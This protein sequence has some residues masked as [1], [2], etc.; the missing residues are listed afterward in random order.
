MTV[1]SLPFAIKT[2]P[3]MKAVPGFKYE[4]GLDVGI[5]YKTE[6]PKAS[7]KIFA[8]GVINT[9]A[10]SVENIEEALPKVVDILKDFR[11]PLK[12]VVVGSDSDSE[13]DL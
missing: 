4:P 9:L 8:G 11:R 10:P 1:T 12:T 13:F 5:Q 6:E 2:N 3:L 7:F